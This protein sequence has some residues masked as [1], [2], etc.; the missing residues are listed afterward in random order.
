MG[1]ETRSSVLSFFFS[2]RLWRRTVRRAVA[3]AA[4]PALGHAQLGGRRNGEERVRVRQAFRAGRP[5]PSGMLGRFAHR[6][7]RIHQVR[8][9][10]RVSRRGGSGRNE[11]AGDCRQP[12]SLPTPGPRERVATQ[13][14]TSLR[15]AGATSLGVASVIWSVRVFLL[16]CVCLSR[17]LLLGCP[18]FFSIFSS[19]LPFALPSHISDRAR[20]WRPSSPLCAP[21]FATFTGL[22]SRT[23]TAA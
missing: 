19:A 2:L 22:K 3:S 16:R 17:L 8:R 4:L 18:C 14:A 23:T 15:P 7:K 1:D 20:V 9:D 21:D 12:L 11:G 5:H 10:L 6:W 13:A